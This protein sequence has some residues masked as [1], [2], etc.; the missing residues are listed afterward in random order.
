MRVWSKYQ[1]G[2]FDF[3]TKPGGNGC[4]EAVAGSGKST[5]IKEGVARLVP[6]VASI[7]CGAFN[8]H[9]ETPLA[10]DLAMYPNVLVKTLNS[11]GNGICRKNIRGF[12]KIDKDNPKS[13]T[14][15]RFEVLGGAKDSETKSRYYKSRWAIDRLISLAKANLLRP[16]FSI[17]DMRELAITYDITLPKGIS[18]EN[19]YGD[20]QA[21][22]QACVKNFRL[23]DFDDQ[24]YLPIYYNWEFPIFDWSFVDE[25]Q[26]LTPMQ[27]EM[28]IRV[29][30][31]GRLM[32]VGDRYQAI[33]QFRG[34]D[35]NAIPNIIERLACTVLP[36]S[37]CYRCSKSVV[38]EAQRIVPHIEYHEESPEGLVT[39]T[40]PGEY[41]KIVTDKDI[42]LCRTTAPL[43]SDCL[44]MIREGRKATVKGRDIGTNLIALVENQ[45]EPGM[46]STEFRDNLLKYQAQENEKY[47]RGG[48]DSAIA[49]LDDRVQTLMCF[50]EACETV[51]GII[52]K[53]NDIFTDYTS[54][55]TFMTVHKSKGLEAPRTFIIK[56]E[57][58]P[59]KMA[60]TEE[61]I[62]AERNIEYVAIT[63][64]QQELHRVR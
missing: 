28:M 20:L 9:I 19:F 8:K 25:A 13:Q 2:V 50:V 35:S 64:A 41:W 6:N 57:L 44:K 33:Y 29:S 56:P 17:E 40:K 49:A 51:D 24:I 45:S 43:V 32:A 31:A 63:R 10:R 21:T 61:A 58:M 18:E 62:Q 15:Y 34:A 14:V 53:I 38:R 22:F 42:V 47:T 7:F 36:L 1:N 54:G 16:G 12:Y 4:T 5:V 30:R 11:F 46:S 55:V 59:H 27:I 39:D 23:L 37:I 26:D 52:K 48:R 3:I 60:K